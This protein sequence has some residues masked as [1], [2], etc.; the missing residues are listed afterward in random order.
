MPITIGTN[1]AS[2]RAQRQLG[3]ATEQLSSAYERLSSGQRIN[4]ASDD[5]A[6]L[7]VATSLKS[8]ARIFS[9]G[10]RNFNDGISLLNVSQSALQ[11]LSSIVARQQELAEQA[12]NG[13]YTSSQRSAL[14]T[15]ASA[16]TS[17]YNRIVQTTSF[18]GIKV[19]DSSVTSGIRLQ[20]GYGSNSSIDITLNQQLI[21]NAPNGTFGAATIVATTTSSSD[22]E[23]ADINNDGYKDI[24]VNGAVLLGNGNGTFRAP[25]TFGG[26]DNFKIGDIN[27][28][29]KLDIVTQTQGSN[30]SRV[31]IGNGDGTFSV[32]QAV[33][34]AGTQN[35]DIELVDLNGDGRKDIVISNYLVSNTN[36]VYLANSDGT[37]AFKANYARN[38]IQ[39][40]QLGSGDVNGDGRADLI[41]GG[42]T[43]GAIEFSIGNGDG[44]FQ[45]PINKTFLTVHSAVGEGA[46]I[47]DL[48][49]DG[50]G[51]LLAQTDEGAAVFLS[52]GNGTFLAPT[53]INNGL[54]TLTDF[55]GILIAKDVN[56]D[57][58][59]DL[60]GTNGLDGI[61]VMKN[62]GNGTFLAATTYAAPGTVAVG[63]MDVADFNGDGVNDIISVSQGSGGVSLMLGIAGSSNSSTVNAIDLTTQG[64]A[65]TALT[66]L[67]ATQDRIS[68][69]LSVVGAA[70]SRL[71][72]AVSN[73]QA[74]SD[75]YIAAAAKITDA[76]VAQ[77]TAELVRLQILQK[78]GTAILA[79][80]NQQPAL[81]LK[82]LG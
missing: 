10:V 54:S 63:G 74:A 4:H 18:N 47:V 51:D 59:L 44:S 9:Q 52:N 70:Q 81:V 82:L 17:E 38:V 42:S 30:T 46:T 60:V 40:L 16:L 67:S 55:H 58:Y 64:G 31:H 36:T 14:N 66:T 53:A 25:A 80:A 5:A 61:F 49:N 12:A 75:N 7:A 2:M 15:E 72:V 37:L 20:G 45:A 79:Q 78:A 19:L 8:D 69:E 11:A 73:L 68:A 39:D 35:Y 6:G 77:E 43:N 34:G 41:M 24:V 65:Q 48:N 3:K 57:G 56:A 29:G 26:G 23:S 62:N 50:Y 32:G 21:S 13:T 33:I 1:I 27:G 22:I 71:V 28:D 76:D